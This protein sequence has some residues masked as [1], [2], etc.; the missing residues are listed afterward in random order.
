MYGF[1]NRAHEAAVDN[2]NELLKQLAEEVKT[3][4]ES[5]EYNNLAPLIQAWRTVRQ[6]I[7]DDRARRMRDTRF[8]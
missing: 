1:K 5:G 2:L 3:A 6:M 8:D 4:T 7:E